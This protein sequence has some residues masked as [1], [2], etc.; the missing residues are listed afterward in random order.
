MTQN[1]ARRTKKTDFLPLPVALLAALTLL[2][3]SAAAQQPP[4]PVGSAP[5]PQATPD[6]S[7]EPF[8]V[9]LLETHA[10]FEND[11]TGRVETS[12]R[13]RVQND[14]G[15][16]ALNELVFAYNSAAER[17]DI[18][19]VRV[20]RADGSTT[21]APPETIQD[22]AAQAV[23]DAPLYSDAREKHINVPALHPGE[24]L[25]YELVEVIREPLVAGQFWYEHDFEKSAVTLGE[26]LELDLPAARTVKLKTR[27]GFDPHMEE[28]S[29]RRIYS[30]T[31]SHKA[32][33][34]EA[35]EGKAQAKPGE[36]PDV[37][38]SSFT[39][40]EELGT[41]FQ[42]LER[43]GAAVTP[44]IQKKADELTEGK[45]TPIEKLEALY[46]YVAVNFRYVSVAFGS[47][48]FEPHAMAAI[49]KNGYA[50]SK[51]K[52]TL[53]AALAAAEGLRADAVLI[54]SQRKLD[55][56]LP[57]PAGFDHVLTRVAAGTEVFCLDTSTEVAPFGF[58]ISA[59]RH[60][61]ALDVPPDGP[62]ALMETPADPPFPVHQIWRLEG[63]VSEL[64]KLDARV[65]YVLRGDNEVLLR[66]AFRRTPQAKWKELGQ[67]IAAS[68]GLR[69]EIDGVK[70]SDPADTHHPFTLEYHIVAPGFLDWSSR[71]AQLAPPL[72]RLALPDA[73]AAAGGL[74]LGSPAEVT[75]EMKV[76]VPARYTAHAPVATSI[77]REYGEYRSAYSAADGVLSAS[78]TLNIRQR[79]IPAGG[80]SD[81]A[82]F[83]HRAVRNDE[84]QSFVL[85]TAAAGTAAIPEKAS[86]QDLVE[87]A[88]RAYSGQKFALAE[89]LLER[90]VT[91]EPGHK[92]AW[93]LLGAVR[94]AQQENAKAIEAFRKQIELEPTDEFAYEGLG[95]A[96]AA[97]EQY[98]DAIASFRK[99]LQVKP[100]DPLAQ[101]SLGATL[102][103]AHRWA[104]A[105]PE[106]EKAVALSPGDPRLYLNLGRAEMN[107]N[108]ADIGQA[109]FEKAV[110]LSASPPVWNSAA[111]ELTVHGVNLE[112]A[113][114]Y[115][116]LAV[117]GAE[118]DL[119]TVTLDKLTPRDLA[120][121]ASLATYWD[122]LGWV[123]F[124]RGDVNRA[125][126]FVEAAW[127][128]D[129]RGE[130]GD[131]LGQIYEKQGKK[132]EAARMYAMSLAAGHPPAET[133]RRLEALAGGATQADALVAHARDDVA[134]IGED[135]LP[136]LVP[137]GTSAS[138]EF[139]VLV[140]AGGRP[141]AAKFI[142]GDAELR[143]AGENI[144][145][146][147]FGPVLPD[148]TPAK[149]VRRGRLGCGATQPVCTFTLI[150]AGQVRTVE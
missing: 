114:K 32:R 84:E 4:A 88:T 134:L 34:E 80:A 62:A 65:H 128:L 96:Q 97:L 25:E 87:A 91:L 51:D 132:P 14:T 15:V 61:Q 45:K 69:G 147:N 28:A 100:L 116:E 74:V 52:H 54:G 42:S 41:W 82:L 95:L 92:R 140:G 53:L 135:T 120:R 125:E 46:D 99:Q 107:L 49:L 89:Q 118:S 13:I 122:T 31:T 64:G 133:R 144:R 94:L 16:R 131:H 78:R 98:D 126:R 23:R 139:F 66:L 138:A 110:E 76:T 93:K 75:I 20:R 5:A 102:G 37:R 8:V 130:A 19:Y 17:M 29:G 148:E 81:Y 39:S 85:E 146:L 12:A 150:P 60:K 112:R 115:A 77:A 103:E 56:E 105:V 73:A 6:Y 117:A 57:S 141:A 121:T 2:H 129:F 143:G 3:T 119:S 106:L 70:P 137:A 48:R 18:P 86:A 58:L 1:K 30:W 21:A 50:D 36:E 35:A 27:P 43:S 63:A 104:E 47:G 38:I 113:Q 67:A 11:G 124:A 111:Y 83:F 71:R 142:R 123:F 145:G 127:R 33:A 26:K 40:W 68:D 136:R 149:L 22:L 59:L 55:P 90:A 10:R 109:A 7:Q 44:E 9:E 108:H 24:I 101:A 72:P 79:E